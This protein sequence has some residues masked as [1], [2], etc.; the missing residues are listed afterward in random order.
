[1]LAYRKGGATKKR[2]IV[3]GRLAAP[4]DV[5]SDKEVA[6][7]EKMLGSN[8]FT[9]V[10]V[11]ADW[12]G[13]CHK[14]RDN[15]WNDLLKMKDRKMNIGAV[16]DDMLPKTSLA[17]SK[18]EGYPTLMLVGN[19]KRPADFMTPEGEK[20][21]AMPNTE[22]ETLQRLLKAA[23]AEAANPVSKPN[24]KIPVDATPVSATDEPMP[25]N[26]SGDVEE[27]IRNA[28]TVSRE[29]PRPVPIAGGGRMMTGGGLM[30]ALSHIL[31]AGAPAAIWLAGATI[32]ARKTRRVKRHGRGRGRKTRRH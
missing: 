5:R 15:T 1:M 29:N 24:V 18:I 9:L 7:F 8:N 32:L 27:T 26:M 6:P 2:K 11:Y 20:T 28:A 10:F 22:K 3:T 30:G 21:N 19:D 4:I 31:K 17:G 16:R 14:F 23:T 25:P 13:H 12:C